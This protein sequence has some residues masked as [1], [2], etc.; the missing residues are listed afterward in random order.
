MVEDEP[1]VEPD[2]IEEEPAP[3]VEEETQ[4]IEQQETVGE[5]MEPE[6]AL[7]E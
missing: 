3:A 6:P 2:L 7:I 5:G 4:I 1:V